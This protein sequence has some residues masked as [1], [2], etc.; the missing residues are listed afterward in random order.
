MRAVVSAGGA[1]GGA[2]GAEVGVFVGAGVGVD[3]GGATVGVACALVGVAGIFVGVAG[4]AVAA[5]GFVV[6]VAGGAVGLTCGAATGADGGVPA[7]S[8][9]LNRTCRAFAFDSNW[10]G[11]SPFKSSTTRSFSGWAPSLICF[12]APF[13]GG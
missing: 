1:T 13:L 12:T 10:G 5:A 3:V 2:V 8:A 11:E 9:I 6:G 4:I 7:L